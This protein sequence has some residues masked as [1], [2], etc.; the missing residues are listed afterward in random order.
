LG[1][2]LRTKHV[3]MPNCFGF[4]H[5]AVLSR[6]ATQQKNQFSAETCSGSVFDASD[7][8][9][10]GGDNLLKAILVIS[11]KQVTEIDL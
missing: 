6:S 9:L 8:D 5:S 10:V 2:V 11:I 4:G 3:V 7:A 1:V